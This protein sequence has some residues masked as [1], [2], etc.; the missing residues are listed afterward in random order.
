MQGNENKQFFKKYRK[1]PYESTFHTVERKML[2]FGKNV[3]L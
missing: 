1:E 2:I 3:A